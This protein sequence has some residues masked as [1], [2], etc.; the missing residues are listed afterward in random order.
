MHDKYYVT[1]TSCNGI[2]TSQDLSPLRSRISEC[3][4]QPTKSQRRK[5]NREKR[6]KSVSNWLTW[7]YLLRPR[8]GLLPP[9]PARRHRPA[10][11]PRP[12][13][14]RTTTRPPA[15]AAA[16]ST[17]RSTAARRGAGRAPRSRA[18]PRG[19]TRR[20][21][22]TPPRTPPSPRRCRRRPRGAPPGTR[23]PRARL[24][25]PATSSRPAWSPCP[26]LLAFSPCGLL[27]FRCGRFA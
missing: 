17:C 2:D 7:R 21:R 27:R 10:G 11:T 20:A 13:R 3:Y 16:A 12:R 6:M 23:R 18:R 1:L 5:K 8:R 14:P 15:R 9:L 26:W 25:L 19:G 4:T 22:S 24:L